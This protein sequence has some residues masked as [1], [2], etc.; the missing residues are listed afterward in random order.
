MGMWYD[1]KVR[2]LRRENILLIHPDDLLLRGIIMERRAFLG[3]LIRFTAFMC[4]AALFAAPPLKANAQDFY[5]E[6]NVLIAVDMGAYAENENVSYPKGTMGKLV[7]GADAPVGESTRAA[8]DNRKYDPANASPVKAPGY[9]TEITYAV[10]DR[11]L[12]PYIGIEDSDTVDIA[13]LKLDKLGARIYTGEPSS[14]QLDPFADYLVIECVAVTE[15]STIWQYTG[16]AYSSRPG[17][18]IQ[19][20]GDAIGLTENEICFFTDTCDKAYE[21]EA[22]VSNGNTFDHQIIRKR[23]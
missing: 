13:D 7:W 3:K 5:G 2:N 1:R 12:L 20:Y 21:K 11:L 18:D 9:R 23:I 19:V 10:G 4:T 17:F 6:G 8:F 15:H 16:E 22:E 14:D